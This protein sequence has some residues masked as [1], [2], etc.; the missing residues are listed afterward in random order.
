MAQLGCSVQQGAIR[1]WQRLLQGGAACALCSPFSA[2]RNPKT[3]QN[4]AGMKPGTPLLSSAAAVQH[5]CMEVGWHIGRALCLPR[6]DGL[7]EG[8]V[9]GTGSRATAEWQQRKCGVGTLSIHIPVSPSNTEKS[10]STCKEQPQSWRCSVKQLSC[11]HNHA[12]RTHGV[13]RRCTVRTS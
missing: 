12:A 4:T 9:G 3:T 7:A 10:H 6:G 5:K 1:C 8:G 13:L 2:Q 11:C